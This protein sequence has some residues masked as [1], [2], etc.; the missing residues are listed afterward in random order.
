[1]QTDRTKYVGFNQ[2]ELR[3]LS[4]GLAARITELRLAL[5]NQLIAQ[6]DVGVQLVRPQL[7]A[8]EKLQDRVLCDIRFLV[9]LE[10][11]KFGLEEEIQ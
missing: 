5:R 1:M 2:V 3:Y 7:R 10:G 6:D 11:T 8:T 4:Y 9:E